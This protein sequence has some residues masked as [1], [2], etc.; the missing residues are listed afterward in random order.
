MKKV[1]ILVSMLWFLISPV[2]HAVDI[3]PQRLEHS[4]DAGKTYS[5]SF[6][7]KNPSDFSVD[8]FISTGQYRYISSQGTIPPPEGNAALPSCESWLEFDK[9]KYAL[10]PGEFVDVKFLIK[11]P[12]ESSGEYL[13]AALFDEKRALQEIKPK[14]NTPNVQVRV[15]PRFSIPVYISIKNTEKIAAE[16]ED[17]STEPEFQKGGLIFNITLKNTGNI[18][19]RPLGTLTILNQKSEVVKNIPIGK[20]LPIFPGYKE[21]IPVLCPKLPAGKYAAIATIEIAKEKILQKKI[22]FQIK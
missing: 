14:E 22:A 3:E 15:I 13:C 10:D 16:I 7:L 18:H 19:I 11:V 21:I 17:I 5:G 8:V 1:L 6:K 4:L 9:K 12:K 2:A 20:T